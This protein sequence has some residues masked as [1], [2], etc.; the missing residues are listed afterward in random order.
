MGRNEKYARVYKADKKKKVVVVGGGVAGT[1]AARTL[2]ERGHDVVLFEKKDR[3]GGLLNDI[4]KLP[5]K[6]DICATRTG[7]SIPR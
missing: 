2:A 1:Q 5:F 7:S 4:D 6:D 3:L